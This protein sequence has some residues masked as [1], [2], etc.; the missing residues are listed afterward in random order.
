MERDWAADERLIAS[1]DNSQCDFEIVSEK[2]VVI[3]ELALADRRRL[4]ELLTWRPG[5]PTEPGRYDLEVIL[6]GR[7]PFLT[8]GEV[9]DN[10][11]I[12]L[13]GSEYR[14]AG[15]EHTIRRHFKIPQPPSEEAANGKD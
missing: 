15:P 10:G 8:C 6:E 9:L 11:G 4:A 1:A 3:A 7:S 12:L 14:Y 13:F 5:P 2:A